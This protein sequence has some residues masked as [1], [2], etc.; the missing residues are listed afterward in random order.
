VEELV[1]VKG[2]FS[3][4][5]AE[6]DAYLAQ[7][8]LSFARQLHDLSA[9]GA[10]Q[11]GVVLTDPDD[12]PAT[13]Q[14]IAGLLDDA[15]VAAYPWE[16]VL[17]EL[18]AYVR[19][20]R[21]SNLILQGIIIFLSLFTIFNTVLMSILERTREFAIQLALGTP[22]GFLRLQVLAESTMLALLGC[23]GGVTV[24][25]AFAIWLQERGWDL[26]DVYGDLDVSGFADD[27]VIHAQVTPGL[28]VG[29]ACIVLGAT[30]LICLLSMRHIS[31]ISVA[32]VLR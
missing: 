26:R 21:N 12:R 32:D 14:Q 16:E 15:D 7:I 20:D 19:V 4:G 3:L 5:V 8:P 24:G 17:P 31:R 6:T 25:G 13:M 30:L 2:I 11:L 29:L 9:T 27:P 23:V 28:I 1:R 10:T 22:S 18:A